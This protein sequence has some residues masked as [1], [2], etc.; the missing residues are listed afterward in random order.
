MWS[1]EEAWN[2]SFQSGKLR[3]FEGWFRVG[4][5]LEIVYK[6]FESLANGNIIAWDLR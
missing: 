2:M 4:F 3:S 6:S 1:E 5:Y